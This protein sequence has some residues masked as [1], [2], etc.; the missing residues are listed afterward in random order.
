MLPPGITPEINAGLKSPFEDI[1]TYDEVRESRYCLALVTNVPIP[2]AECPKRREAFQ[3]AQR[4]ML[5]SCA[6][7]G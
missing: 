1:V 7:S 6:H 4:S 2:E 3:K 5:D